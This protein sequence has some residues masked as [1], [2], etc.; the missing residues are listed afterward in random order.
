MAPL[1]AAPRL[2]DLVRDGALDEILA[3]LN[4]SA[5]ALG[6]PGAT[7]AGGA[8]EL[9]GATGAGGDAALAGRIDSLSRAIDRLGNLFHF[10]RSEAGAGK[11]AAAGALPGD[12]LLPEARGIPGR[13]PERGKRPRAD[14]VSRRLAHVLER[15]VHLVLGR[16]D[17][18]LA[19]YGTLVP[20]ERNHHHVAGLGGTWQR[21]FVRGRR[22]TADDG[23]PRFLWDP[24][25]P[26]VEAMLLVSDQLPDAWPRLDSFEGEP[27]RRH[28]VPARAEDAHHVVYLYEAAAAREPI[29]KGLSSPEARGASGAG[30]RVRRRAP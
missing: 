14:R 16:P 5:D 11:S 29:R 30:S 22:W 1:H 3:D 6:A 2:S 28:L 21:C 18:K 20:G 19:A 10:S 23:D 12:V 26:E 9:V 4:R 25:E 15:V 17:R 7:R 27:Y 8:A 13:G 24:R